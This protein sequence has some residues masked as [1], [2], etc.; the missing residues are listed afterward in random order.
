MTPKILTALEL[1]R[2][3]STSMLAETGT[4]SDHAMLILQ[5][6]MTEIPE[7]TYEHFINSS[8]SD[9]LEQTDT[10]LGP[11]SYLQKYTGYLYE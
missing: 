9:Q 6:Y 8:L 4:M 3:I 10:S 11:K 5:L 7:D 1:T 2:L